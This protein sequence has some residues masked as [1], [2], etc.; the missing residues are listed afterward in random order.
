MLKKVLI[1]IENKCN[2]NYKDVIG[3]LTYLTGSVRHDIAM[4]IHQYTQFSTNSMRLNE[5]AVMCIEQCLLAKKE[6]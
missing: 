5:K 2:W 4:A 3:M 1:G 6:A